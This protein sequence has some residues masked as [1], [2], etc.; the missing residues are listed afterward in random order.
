MNCT[1]CGECD[2]LGLFDGTSGRCITDTSVSILEISM[3]T[4]IRRSRH[5]RF[6]FQSQPTNPEE[7]TVPIRLLTFSQVV[8]SNPTQTKRGGKLCMCLE[9]INFRMSC[10]ENFMNIGSS[11][12]KSCKKTQTTFSDTR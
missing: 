2:L 8:H 11:C 10:G 9:A 7:N 1:Y 4:V 6:F 5:P 3:N 12:F